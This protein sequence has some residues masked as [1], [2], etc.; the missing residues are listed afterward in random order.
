MAVYEGSD[1]VLNFDCTETI[2][3]P[4]KMEDD[5]YY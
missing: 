4:N 1:H 5:H 3:V 2:Q